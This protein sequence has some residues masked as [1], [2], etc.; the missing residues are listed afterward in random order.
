MHDLRGWLGRV[1]EIVAAH[2]LGETGAY[3][4]WRAPG[5][6]RELG[7]N[8]YGSADAAN[9]LYTLGRFPRDPKERGG[10]LDALQRFQ[11]PATGLFREDSHD[12]I[13]TTAH[14]L[15]ALELFD[16]GPRHPLR[17]L[18]PLAA[19]G[20]LEDFLDGLDWRGDPWRESHR[21]AGVYAARWLAGECDADF[22]D[23]YVAWLAREC[24][25]ASGLWRR[26]AVERP[27]AWGE[28]RFPHL[29]GTFHYL[30]NLRARPPAPPAPGRPGRHL[31]RHRGGR[32]LAARPERR[33]R[34]GGLGLLP[35]AQRRARAATAAARPSPPCA[36]SPT[37][38][39][40]SWRI[41]TST[42]TT[43]PAICTG[44]SVRSARWRSCSGCCRAN[45]GASAP[46]AWC[47]TA[48]PSSEARPLQR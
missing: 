4:R 42:P 1:E 5:A 32:R 8:P 15:A 27:Y 31:P 17:A 20:A 36:A 16:A 22:E 44:C 26:G 37:V 43:A 19:P 45:S 2:A 23:R 13:H 10:W 6:G 35:G 12:P 47:S 3:G 41:S 7:P 48:G 30:F 40:G 18:A 39:S 14:C 24:D 29:A 33:L 38:T 9:L 21:G 25:P 11:D 28:S 46:C 34:R